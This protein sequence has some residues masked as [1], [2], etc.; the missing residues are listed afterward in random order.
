VRSYNFQTAS[1]GEGIFCS[2]RI[3]GYSGG[4]GGFW[5]RLMVD[6]NFDS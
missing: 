2:D 6:S 4:E 5:L 1:K 3:G